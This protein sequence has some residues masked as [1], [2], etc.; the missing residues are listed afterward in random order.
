MLKELKRWSEI[1]SQECGLHKGRYHILIFLCFVH[2]RH[3]ICDTWV[4]TYYSDDYSQL[5]MVKLQCPSESFLLT[6]TFSLFILPSITSQDSK[7][8]AGWAELFLPNLG[9]SHSIQAI[10]TTPR[11]PAV[12]LEV[13]CLPL[14]LSLGSEYLSV[15]CNNLGVP[16]GRFEFAPLSAFSGFR[17]GRKN[18]VYLGSWFSF[19][20]ILDSEVWGALSPSHF[21][22]LTKLSFQITE[23]QF[24]F[25]R[26]RIWSSEQGCYLP[27]ASEPMLKKER[28]LKARA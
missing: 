13:Q 27:E 21:G 18:R 12:Q 6:I 3:L 5:L 11:V 26:C 4:V 7:T 25:Y 15:F 23:H 2:S 14:C 24:S 20:E 9:H 28:N 1:I 16:Q 22:V 19:W 8:L 17:L 10:S